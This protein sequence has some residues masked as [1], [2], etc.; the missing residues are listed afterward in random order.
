[1]SSL[2]VLAA[3]SASVA[4]PCVCCG[5]PA[6]S[7]TAAPPCPRHHPNALT[8]A[9]EAARASTRRASRILLGRPRPSRF[10]ALPRAPAG[11]N[12]AETRPVLLNDEDFCLN[13]RRVPRESLGPVQISSLRIPARLEG[14]PRVGT[15]LPSRAE[16]CRT[17]PST[18]HCLSPALAGRAIRHGVQI[19]GKEGALGRHGLVVAVGHR[20]LLGERGAQIIEQVSLPVV[21]AA[22]CVLVGR[23]YCMGPCC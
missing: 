7:S 18:S 9:H 10:S 22:L 1:M 11:F 23:G 12:R 8:S 4:L 14:Y 21:G 2:T 6:A 16:M 20:G 17:V 5:P 15:E 19:E 3:P 13:T